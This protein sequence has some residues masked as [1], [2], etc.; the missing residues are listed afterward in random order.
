MINFNK[1]AIDP[2]VQK[3]HDMNEG[4]L[5]ANKIIKKIKDNAWTIAMS[6][7]ESSIQDHKNNIYKTK[8]II[9]Q[10]KRE[11]Q[12]KMN[13][14]QNPGT[15]KYDIRVKFLTHRNELLL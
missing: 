15:D 7:L 1:G 10:I 5:L 8:E 6:N 2:Q 13:S 4:E 11:V 12:N 3:E 9:S 14:D